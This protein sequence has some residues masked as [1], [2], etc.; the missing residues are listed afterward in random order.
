M[1]SPEELAKL[2]ADGAEALDAAFPD[3]FDA[4]IAAGRGPTDLEL[5]MFRRV[6]GTGSDNEFRSLFAR[7]AA[8]RGSS[9]LANH[10][11]R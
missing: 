1:N 10:L 5:E 6:K 11:R 4:M 7:H 3:L 9:L 8:S 2:L